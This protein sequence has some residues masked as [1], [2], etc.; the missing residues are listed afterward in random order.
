MGKDEFL[1]GKISRDEVEAIQ[2]L[3]EPFVLS[4]KTSEGQSI[5]SAVFCYR[6]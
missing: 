3:P 2:E 4:G 5:D 6:L 1:K